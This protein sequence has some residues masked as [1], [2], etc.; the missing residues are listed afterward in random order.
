MSKTL[1]VN[2]FG[3]PGSGKSTTA[4]G[5][6]HYLKREG[7]N[8]EYIQEYAKDVVWGENFK[9]LDNQIYVYGKQ[10]NR[11]FRLKGKVDVIITDAPP[12]MGMVYCDWTKT[13]PFL[14]ELAFEEHHRD[15]VNTLNFFIKRAKPYN[16]SGRTQDAEGAKV[17]DGE[18]RTLL[19]EYEIEF[20]EV[21]GDD[22]IVEFI[23]AMIMVELK[24]K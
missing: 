11:I 3:G 22:D 6:F 15:D 19:D 21:L 9:T 18:I 1:I 20:T 14:S 24:I 12:I 7:V 5:V 16:P 23:L 8:C 2:L 10:H 4:A 17:V 13:S